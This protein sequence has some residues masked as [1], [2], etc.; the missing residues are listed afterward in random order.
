[1]DQDSTLVGMDVHKKNLTVAILP[2][3]IARPVKVLTIENRWQSDRTHGDPTD[4]QSS[5]VC[6]RGGSVRI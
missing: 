5:G 3:G 2:P 4:Y 6:L 1:M